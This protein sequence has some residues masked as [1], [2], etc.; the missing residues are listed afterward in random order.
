M[1]LPSTSI[2][3]VQCLL[4]VEPLHDKHFTVHLIMFHISTH[5]TSHIRQE[6]TKYFVYSSICVSKPTVQLH[7]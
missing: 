7:I 5:S 3:R 6:T 1:L 2:S 4:V